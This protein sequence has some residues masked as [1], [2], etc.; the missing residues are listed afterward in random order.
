[1]HKRMI[2]LLSLLLVHA[3]LHA[4]ETRPPQ[5]TANAVLELEGEASGIV[6]G[7]AELS[8]IWSKGAFLYHARVDNAQRLVVTQ[9]HVSGRVADTVIMENVRKDDHNGASLGVDAAGYIHVTGDQHNGSVSSTWNYWVSD[10]PHDIAAFTFRGGP[11]WGDSPSWLPSNMPTY[12]LFR[13]DNNDRLYVTWRGRLVSDTSKRGF[14]GLMLAVLEASP[15]AP[16]TP[17]G[18]PHPEADHWPALAVAW[19][20]YG[21]PS[22]SDITKEEPYQ[23]FRGHTWF[24]MRNRL[25]MAWVVYAAGARTPGAAAWRGEVGSGATHLMYAV[26]PDGGVSW[27]DIRGRPL[28]LPIRSEEGGVVLRR[29]P[30]DLSSQCFLTVT[31]DGRPVITYSVG[32]SPMHGKHFVV[33]GKRDGTWEV[34]RAL[35]VTSRGNY[36]LVADQAGIWTLPGEEAWL[37]S[38]DEGKTWASH[39]DLPSYP[40][41]GAASIDYRHL[42]ETGAIRY[43]A[44]VEKDGDPRFEVWTVHFQPSRSEA[45]LHR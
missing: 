22:S 2:M 20:P 4:G 9:K 19:E 27:R 21:R 25:H 30:G 10:K 7:T 36:R 16:W 13:P 31:K 8:P 18:A 35:P 14:R 39:A 37:R 15:P 45:G 17:R 24:D 11:V 33:V 28:A 29:D 23:T 12:A 34:P 26:S 41:G 6:I 42:R 43:H 1:M 44:F 32:G 40:G 38:H 3:L 5:E